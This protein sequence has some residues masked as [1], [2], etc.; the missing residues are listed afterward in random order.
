MGS[1][2]RKI[3]LHLPDMGGD[4]RVR[5]EVDALSVQTVHL[6]RLTI[7][8]PNNASL[9]IS[10][11]N[12]EKHTVQRPAGHRQLP[13]DRRPFHMVR[14]HYYPI[15]STA[16]C[17]IADVASMIMEVGKDFRKKFNR[18][19]ENCTTQVRCRLKERDG[20]QSTHFRWSELVV[21]SGHVWGGPPL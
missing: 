10:P 3:G 2:R 19:L 11:K 13:D 7:I 18:K 21:P 16:E 15:K 20:N 8:R 17:G 14:L 5:Q 9:C 4:G 12:R 6:S 1:I